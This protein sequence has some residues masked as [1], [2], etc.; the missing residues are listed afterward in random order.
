MFPR[1][2]AEGMSNA[3][4]E[5]MAAGLP[6]VT[7]ATVSHDMVLAAGC[8]ESVDP[9]DQPAFV[10]TLRKLNRASERQR[11]ARA[12]LAHART[13]TWRASVSQFVPAFQDVID[14][15][16]SAASS[17]AA[18]RPVGRPISSMTND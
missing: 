15:R 2:R 6:I 14:S 12:S 3:C 7:T 4:L 16:V 8:G 17:F 9:T 13:L 18:S 11:Y 10:R 5:A 1:P